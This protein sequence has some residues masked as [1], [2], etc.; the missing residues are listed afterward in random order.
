MKNVLYH[1]CSNDALFS[2][3]SGSS[4]RLSSL[5]QSN[6]TNEGR[7][8]TGLV[9]DILEEH[10]LSS[11]HAYELTELIDDFEA[12]NVGFGL[13]LSEKGD[14]LSQWRGYAN[15]AS[16]VSIGFS[17]DY[18][19]FIAEDSMR[20][21]LLRPIEYDRESQVSEIALEVKS[22]VTK[23]TLLRENFYRLI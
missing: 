17:S 6:D 13:C 3:I 2:I 7:L 20:E 12:L 11:D 19:N 23:L 5:L 10:D 16:G 21:I 18:L 22:M 14:L 4:I 8:V 15:D 9:Q 1:Y